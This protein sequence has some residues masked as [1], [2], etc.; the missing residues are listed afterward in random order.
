[1]KLCKVYKFEDTDETDPLWQGLLKQM[2][3]WFKEHGPIHRHYW[4]WA[5][6]LYGLDTLGYV[7]PDARAL[8]VGAGVEWPLFY[9]AN[10]VKRVHAIDLY[11]GPWYT[12]EKDPT[13]PGN[14]ERLAPFPYRGEAL[15]FQRMDALDLK[16]ADDSFDF[17]FSFSSIEHFNAPGFKTHEASS[18]AMREIAR[19]LKPGG[20]AAISTELLLEDVAHPEYFS[21]PEIESYLVRPSGLELVEPVDYVVDERLLSDPVWY[22]G[23]PGSFDPSVPHTSIRLGGVIFTSVVLFLRK[24][25]GWR[26]RGRLPMKVRVQSRRLAGS[27]Q[28]P[29]RGVLRKFIPRK[30]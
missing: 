23:P 7:Q 3:P 2:C 29:V 14:A 22:D 26:P 27:L 18:W 13:V 20:V 17:V 8:S 30:Q 15:I 16:F 10:R 25:A 9:L 19:V 21:L 28:T 5:V 24:P 6:G 1:M 4:E 12:G 11:D